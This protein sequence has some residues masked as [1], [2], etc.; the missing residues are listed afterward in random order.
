MEPG[1]AP[2]AASRTVRVDEMKYVNFNEAWTGDLVVGALFERGNSYSDQANVS[3]GIG[4]RTEEDRWTFTGGY[5]FGRQRDPGT[6]AKT[7]TT[8]NWYATTTG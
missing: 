2:G 3:F 4:R 6:G 5:N 7:T 8:E 1:A